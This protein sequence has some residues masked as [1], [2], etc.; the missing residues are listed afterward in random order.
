M[1]QQSK[2]WVCMGACIGVTPTGRHTRS[3][4]STVTSAP[5]TEP[6]LRHHL[7]ASPHLVHGTLQPDYPPSCLSSIPSRC[8][9]SPPA[10]SI[11]TRLLVVSL[12]ASVPTHIAS[13]L[14]GVNQ[15]KRCLFGQV[16]GLPHRVRGGEPGGSMSCKLGQQPSPRSP[17]SGGEPERLRWCVVGRLQRSPPI[18]P[19]VVVYGRMSAR[20][21]EPPSGW[22]LLFLVLPIPT[23]ASEWG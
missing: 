2:A 9:A 18:W 8:R 23:C 4:R 11:S 15:L 22:H 1:A 5:W 14:V 6:S 13:R 19:S 10:P 17:S 20:G 21:G 7:P 16:T 3:P 12:A